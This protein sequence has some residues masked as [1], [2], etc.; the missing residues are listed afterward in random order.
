MV[1]KEH[2]I[3][4]ARLFSAQLQQYAVLFGGILRLTV[5]K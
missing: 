4:A 3:K 1:V 2:G 5:S